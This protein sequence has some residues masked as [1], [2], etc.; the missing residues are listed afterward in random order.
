MHFSIGVTLLAASALVY[1]LTYIVYAQAGW[2][3][4]RVGHWA[5]EIG[6]W[7]RFAGFVVLIRVALEGKYRPFW[8]W[9]LWLGSIFAAL[10]VAYIF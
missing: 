2:G 4:P 8:V 6:H 1:N 5:F 10:S 7:L 3:G 9:T